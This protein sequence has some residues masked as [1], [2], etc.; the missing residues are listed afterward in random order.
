LGV[1]IGV[2]VIRF[3]A[4]ASSPSDGCSNCDSRFFVQDLVL[5]ALAIPNICLDLGK[6]IVSFDGFGVCSDLLLDDGLADVRT[7]LRRC[8]A[9][10]S[11]GWL[12][13]V[14]P[15]QSKSSQVPS[16][17]HAK[18]HSLMVLEVVVEDVPAYRFELF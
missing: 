2:V 4:D 12:A 1:V 14:Y 18:P 10:S 6:F 17:I 11:D 13:S 3:E 7:F 8:L 9:K 15:Q 5:A 16:G